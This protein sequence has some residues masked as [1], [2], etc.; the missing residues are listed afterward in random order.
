MAVLISIIGSVVVC[1][2]IYMVYAF[3]SFLDDI[4]VS[5]T[6]DDVEGLEEDFKNG[7]RNLRPYD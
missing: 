6:E 2:M 7:L 4:D 5:L 1:S 3:F